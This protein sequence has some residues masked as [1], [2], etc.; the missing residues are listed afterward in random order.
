MNI[1]ETKI[2]N[3]FVSQK[4]ECDTF[5]ETDTHQV[6]VFSDGSVITWTNQ[7]YTYIRESFNSM[8]DFNKPLELAD[9]Y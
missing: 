9:Y 7:P 2:N 6:L 4:E 1:A 5:F 3:S 8:D